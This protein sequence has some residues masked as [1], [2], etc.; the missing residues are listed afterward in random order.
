MGVLKMSIV[1]GT[2][3]HID[4]GKTTLIKALTGIDCDRLKDEKKRGITIEL[5]F[6]Y[7]DLPNGVRLSIV[8]VPGHEKFVKNM[9]AGASGIDFVLLTVAADE[10]IMPQTREH[11]EICSLLGIEKGIVALSKVD[12]V[13]EEL[14]ELAMEDV[15]EYLSNTFLKD[16]R[17]I[18]VSAHTGEGIDE[19]IQALVDMVEKIKQKKSS[20][21]FVLPVDRVFTLKGHGTVITGTLVSGDIA[22]GEDIMVYPDEKISKVRHI[23]VHGESVEKVKAGRR[24]A[25]NLANL[26]VE[27]IKRG[28]ILARPET[29]FPSTTWDIEISC[30]SSS[31]RPLL[32]RKE[33][34]FHH[35]TTEVLARIYLLDKDR[36]EPG[37]KGYAQVRFP[38][39]MVGLF[40]DRFVIRS[41][42]P[43]RT[44]GGGKIINPL[45]QK[46]KRFSE[47]IKILKK[48]SEA[49]IE[50]KIVLHLRRAGYNGLSL[51]ALH[52]LTNMNLKD[53]TKALD[54]LGS[55]QE[56]FMFDREEKIY[57]SAECLKKLREDLIKYFKKFHQKNP[58][59]W[60]MPKGQI[61]SDWGKDLNHKLVHFVV[62]SCIKRN[63]IVAEEELLK[64]AGHKVA[65]NKGQEQLKQKVLQSFKQSLLTPPTVKALIQ[66]LGVEKKEL[67]AILKILID[68]GSLIKV[69][70]EM[71]FY[72]DAI[73]SIREKIK[74]FFKEHEEMRPQD[75]KELTGLTRKYS[76]PLLEY[77]DK[78]KLTIRVGD[79]RK[80][81]KK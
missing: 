80:L 19:L 64:L 20:D 25:I 43:L 53:L 58:L 60:G 27:D 71:Y 30:L 68:E 36:L 21:I 4:H 13:D 78:E 66:D 3:G 24:T 23:Q 76:I 11:I 14:L 47:D 49:N 15:K 32:H 54:R 57:I 61:L 52:V 28:D 55:K 67:T 69:K 35:G 79:V 8:D 37:D 31:P 18:P 22:V 70:E 56:I 33:V 45:G 1:M 38:H 7:L 73:F 81:R 6:A 51:K 39:P 74:S 50:E 40:G 75:F 77:F 63:L 62:E 29:L 65:L 72:K 10:G 46:I 44:I 12:M 9:V 59:D 41:F 5:G 34:H 48:L 17:I 16:S 26:E 2:A 42:S